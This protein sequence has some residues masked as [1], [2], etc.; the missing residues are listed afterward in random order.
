MRVIVLLVIL[1]F[2]VWT[3]P[4]VQA[5]LNGLKG[6]DSR[7]YID[8]IINSAMDSVRNVIRNGV[9]SLNI[10]PL[11]PFEI[12]QLKIDLETDAASLHL[13][14]DNT[15]VS[16]LADFIVESV[17]SNL[18]QL[19]MNLKLREPIF[20]IDGQYA[21]DGLIVSLFPLYGSGSYSIQVTNSTIG[22]GAGLSLS[23]PGIKNLYLDFTF[24]SME[25][26]F[27]NL[28]GGGLMQQAVETAVNQLAKKVV[29]TIWPLI[30][31]PLANMI[32]DIINQALV[33]ASPDTSTSQPNQ[34]GKVLMDGN[35]YLDDIFR[36][37][38]NVLYN[39]GFDPLY[40]LPQATTPISGGSASIY[41]GWLSGLSTVHR[42]GDASLES[43]G[44]ILRPE[45]I[46]IANAGFTNMLA[47]YKVQVESLGIDTNADLNALI[48]G[49]DF[50]FQAT[51]KPAAKNVTIDDFTVWNIGPFTTEVTGLGLLNWAAGD[52]IQLALNS[53]SDLLAETLSTVIQNLL[54]EALTS[55][56]PETPPELFYYE[57]Y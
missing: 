45:F 55:K 34:D 16:H 53:L 15:V 43:K 51:I 33:G 7:N 48:K 3:A 49:V 24:E 22:G 20:R 11:D 27:E 38:R 39:S 50:R 6:A 47:G 46:L 44:T 17:T 57:T 4:S 23:P 9:P 54:Q 21:L 42:S 37:L 10:P 52:I 26:K 18:I 30:S 8:D 28:L 35:A 25:V 19:K 36:D 13:Q 41:N 5:P 2:G 56:P 14:I 40:P 32:E 12:P 31:G 29:D 1:P